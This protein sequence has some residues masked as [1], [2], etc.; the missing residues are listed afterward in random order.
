MCACPGE[1]MST[2]G[3]LQLQQG[4]ARNVEAKGRISFVRSAEAGMA[5]LPNRTD[6]VV[7]GT[8][9]LAGLPCKACTQQCAY[10]TGIDQYNTGILHWVQRNA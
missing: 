1:I 9:A 5:T 6:I 2:K 4:C 8:L 7:G 3:R 10:R